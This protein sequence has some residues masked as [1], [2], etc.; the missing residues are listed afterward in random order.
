MTG[1]YRGLGE[2]PYH[3][4][5]LLAIVVYRYATGV[6][7]S[8]K[9]GRATYNS[10]AFRFIAANDHPDHDTIAAFRRR[11]LKQ[12]ET[13]FVQVLLLAGE[14][15]VLKLGI[16]ALDGTKM[17]ANARRHGALWHEYAGKIE[18]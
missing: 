13:L 5:F 3:P 2:A 6:F 12:I 17:H 9:L 7:S 4:R 18:A 11:F 16:V 14:M 1:S 15:R 10:V 8:R